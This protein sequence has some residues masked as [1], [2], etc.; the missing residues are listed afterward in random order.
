MLAAA[1]VTVTRRPTLPR[2]CHGGE[3]GEPMSLV[4]LGTDGAAAAA[5]LRLA[6]PRAW[7][8]CGRA[9]PRPLAASAST[10]RGLAALPGKEKNRRGPWRRK[11][12]GPAAAARNLDED[13]Q[14]TA[15]VERV[16]FH[17]AENGYS[18]VRASVE[19]EA[20]AVTLCGTMHGTANFC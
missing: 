8:R 5:S 15:Q 7:L 10:R 4:W 20:G 18:V 16:T 6:G 14:M 9:V 3:A 19:G 2:C 13:V 11:A 17:N 12:A 1:A